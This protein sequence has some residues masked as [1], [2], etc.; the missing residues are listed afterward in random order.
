MRKFTTFDNELMLFLED[1]G[2]NYSNTFKGKNGD[3]GYDYEFI[4]NL[5][6]LLNEYRDSKN[7]TKENIEVDK[8]AEFEKMLKD[9]LKVSND[10]VREGKR[11]HTKAETKK[12]K[13]ESA[14]RRKI[15]L[16]KKNKG[17]G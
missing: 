5:R 15:A 3:D 1:K 2:I 6:R 10:K 11:E 12:N 14:F 13:E 7:N 8:V 9:F 17:R 16:A 4:P